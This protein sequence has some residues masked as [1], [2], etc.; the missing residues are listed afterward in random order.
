MKDLIISGLVVFSG[1]YLAFLLAQW[2]TVFTTEWAYIGLVGPPVVTIE[3]GRRMLGWTAR[4]KTARMWKEVCD[5]LA[6]PVRREGKR[7]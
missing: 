1:G 7:E 6:A 3:L 4:R 5:H 2:S